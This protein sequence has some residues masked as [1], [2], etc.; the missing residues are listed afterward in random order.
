MTT[1]VYNINDRYRVYPALNQVQDVQ[2]GYITHLEPRIMAVLE[3]L[4]RYAGQLATRE[5]MILDIWNNYGGGDEGLSQAISLL[6]KVLNDR[7]KKLIQTIPKKG[8]RLTGTLSIAK[9]QDRGTKSL[10][11]RLLLRAAVL[12]Y[13]IGTA[14]YFLYNAFDQ[15]QSKAKQYATLVTSLEQHSL[16]SNARPAT[17]KFSYVRVDS[18]TASLTTRRTNTNNASDKALPTPADH[19]RPIFSGSTE[20]KSYHQK[21]TTA[22]M[23][24]ALDYQVTTTMSVSTSIN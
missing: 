18:K 6:R 2:T 10:N 17:K 16:P 15:E 3:Y 14:T 13:V 4:S 8:N 5:A 21:D 22:Q 9:I 24:T 19:P 23:I 12:L 7:E 11:L 20:T 1:G